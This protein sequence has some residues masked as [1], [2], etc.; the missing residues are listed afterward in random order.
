MF[1]ILILC[2]YSICIL[3]LKKWTCWLSYYFLVD[4]THTEQSRRLVWGTQLPSAACF[5][6]R[7]LVFTRH[8]ELNVVQNFTVA[9]SRTI[10]GGSIVARMWHSLNPHPSP[11]SH[12]Q[13]FHL[14]PHQS[15][16]THGHMNWT[17]IH[18]VI[19]ACATEHW[20]LSPAAKTVSY[21]GQSGR[22]FLALARPRNELSLRFPIQEKQSSVLLF[23]FIYLWDWNQ[24]KS[25]RMVSSGML[26]RVAL[27]R[28]DVPEELSASFIRVTSSYS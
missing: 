13:S 16:S 7:Q 25:T 18:V 12:T 19:F 22:S 27:V 3:Q 26:R 9:S 24:N 1:I 5:E 14:A 15:V 17:G 11:L 4:G 10:S 20:T 8:N 21:T 28:T 23:S 6:T 2:E